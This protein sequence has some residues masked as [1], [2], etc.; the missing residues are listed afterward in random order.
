MI[1]KCAQCDAMFPTAERVL[2]HMT[3]AHKQRACADCSETFTCKLLWLQHRHDAHAQPF[4]CRQCHLVLLSALEL[5]KHEAK[6][7]RPRITC[8]QCPRTFLREIGLEAHVRFAHPPPPPPKVEKVKKQKVEKPQPQ[9][10]KCGKVFTRVNTLN[11]HMLSHDKVRAHICPTCGKQFCSKRVLFVHERRHTSDFLFKC[12]EVDCDFGAYERWKMTDHV[13]EMHSGVKLME[14]CPVCDKEVRKASLYNHVQNHKNIEKPRP[15]K[16][17]VCERTFTSPCFLKVHLDR[18]QNERR[19][20]CDRCDKCFNT[21]FSMLLHWNCHLGIKVKCGECKKKFSSAASLK[22]HKITH[23]GLRPFECEECGKT[24]TQ[25][26][27]LV[28]HM[29][30]FHPELIIKERHL[31]QIVYRVTSK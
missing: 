12:E 24:F 17:G 21:R 22:R 29:K 30:G 25:R 4:E 8:S 6:A 7:H 31:A 11:R 15:Y 19:F 23:T 20:R 27:T 3:K 16:C 5:L 10:E 9:C 13:T 14:R 1:L 26:T 2:R 28:T 18:H